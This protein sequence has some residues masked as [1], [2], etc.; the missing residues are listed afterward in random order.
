LGGLFLIPL[1][2][3][4]WEYG[5][6]QMVSKL[7]KYEKENTRI[8]ITDKYDQPYILVLFYKK[9]DPVKYQPQAVLSERDKFNF[10]TVRSFDNYEFHKITPEEI[11]K[12]PNV[13]FIA[14]PEEAGTEANIIDSV[15]FPNGEKAF[16]FVKS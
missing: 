14:S 13:L 9:Y 1:Y 6:S 12:N 4:S 15:D 16:V 10:G 8:V 11:K 2:H 5:F 3:L 7:E